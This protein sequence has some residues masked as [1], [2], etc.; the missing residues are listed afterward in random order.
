MTTTMNQG[1]DAAAL[2]G[3]ILLALIFVDSG[4]GKIGGFAEIAGY[5]AS[6]GLP[7]P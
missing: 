1:R 2:V 4:F 3:R 6:K 5:I 7:M